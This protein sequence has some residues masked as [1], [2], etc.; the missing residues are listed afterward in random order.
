MSELN[1][2]TLVRGAAWSIPVVAIAAQAPA[3]AAST[4]PPRP[5][6]TACKE[7]AGSKCYRFFLT[8]PTPTYDWTITL[9]SLNMKNSTTPAT[10]EELIARTTPKTF[11]VTTSGPNVVQIQACTTG[12]LASS[13]DVVLKYTAAR[14]GMAGENVTVTYAFPSIDPCK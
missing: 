2:R 3:F 8:F 13:G 10:G 1:R 6:A 11:P 14:T 4:D 12:N 7:T 9:T 5:S